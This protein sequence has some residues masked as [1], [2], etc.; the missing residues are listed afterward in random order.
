[1]AN[2]SEKAISILAGN[3]NF[4]R[5]YLITIVKS[6]MKTIGSI[7]LKRHPDNSVRQYSNESIK[8]FFP[9]DNLPNL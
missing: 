2:I 6:S 5:S 8:T 4:G 9:N 1:M 7:K 3:L